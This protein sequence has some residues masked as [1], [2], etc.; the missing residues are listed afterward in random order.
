MM[1]GFLRCSWCQKR[2][3]VLE[4]RKVRVKRLYKVEERTVYFCN[5]REARE[6]GRSIG[7]RFL[8]WVR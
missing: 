8:G 2:A 5:G 4:A 1:D 7:S 3:A 6:W